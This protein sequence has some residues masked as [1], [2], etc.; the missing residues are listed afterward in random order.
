M[1]LV[2][3]SLSL[4]LFFPFS[5]SLMS[6]LSVTLSRQVAC[7][8]KMTQHNFPG[9]DTPTNAIEKKIWIAGSDS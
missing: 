4:F 5:F 1:I 6:L 9:L 3:V 2:D 8:T 7:M